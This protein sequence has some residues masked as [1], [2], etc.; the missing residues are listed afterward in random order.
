MLLV[1]HPSDNLHLLIFPKLYW[2]QYENIYFRKVENTIAL[3]KKDLRES[4]LRGL[5]LL[6]DTIHQNQNISGFA[7]IIT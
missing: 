7:P 5:K 3:K 6:G 1:Y 2:Q 4:D